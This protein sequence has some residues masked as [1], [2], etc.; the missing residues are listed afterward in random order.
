MRK[1]TRRKG[2]KVKNVLNMCVIEC[3]I[4]MKNMYWKNITQVAKVIRVTY[5]YC[6]S[7]TSGTGISH[8]LL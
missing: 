5:I 6:I 1:R 8:L 7:G 2:I 4:E 3:I